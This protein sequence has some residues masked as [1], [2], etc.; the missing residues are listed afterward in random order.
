MP[1]I[2]MT[3]WGSIQ[4]AVEG[5]KRGASDFITKPWANATVLQSV[6]TALKLVEAR[7]AA[8]TGP[9]ALRARRAL[10]LLE[11]HRHATRR[12]CACWR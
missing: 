1:V 3:A 11:H 12:S 10:R 4:L 7:G 8:E 6:E 9:H 5:M 2:L